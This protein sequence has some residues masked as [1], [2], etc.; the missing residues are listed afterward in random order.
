MVRGM[1]TE[2]AVHDAGQ[3]PLPVRRRALTIVIRDG[4]PQ[5][6]RIENLHR[7]APIA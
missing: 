5:S 1:V 4:V 3:R 7:R 2:L 6:H